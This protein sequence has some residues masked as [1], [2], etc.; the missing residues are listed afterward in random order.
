MLYVLLNEI[1]STY[2]KDYSSYDSS[3]FS[4][5]TNYN[6]LS[7]LPYWLVFKIY[8]FFTFFSAMILRTLEEMALNSV[9]AGAVAICS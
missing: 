4:E 8:G 7:K 9:T 2:I 5:Q 1:N 6:E 3:K